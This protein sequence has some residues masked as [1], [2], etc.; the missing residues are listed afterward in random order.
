MAATARSFPV[1]REA[2]ASFPDRAHFRQAVSGLLAPPS[3]QPLP[4]AEEHPGGLVA[5]GLSDEIKYIGP[6][7]VAGII[8]VSSGPIGATVAALVGAGLGGLAPQHVF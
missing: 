8:L 3:H 5:A 6:L 4:I 7:T 1:V 2:V